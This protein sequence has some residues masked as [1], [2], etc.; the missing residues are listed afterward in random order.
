MEL[1][2]TE[3]DAAPSAEPAS[4]TGESPCPEKFRDAERKFLYRCFVRAARNKNGWQLK[5][6]EPS[7]RWVL[8]EVH[9]DLNSAS[10]YVINHQCVLKY[11]GFSPMLYPSEVRVLRELGVKE[12]QQ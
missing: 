2:V 10:E 8:Q 1:E 3:P 9:R 6:H 4:G 5:Y 7:N 11:P 12:F